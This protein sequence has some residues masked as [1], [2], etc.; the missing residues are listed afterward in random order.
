MLKFH[1]FSSVFPVYV[2]MIPVHRILC[3]AVAS[4]PRVCGDDPARVATFHQRESCSPCMW[5]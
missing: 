2:G 1:R 4:V 5:G 3:T